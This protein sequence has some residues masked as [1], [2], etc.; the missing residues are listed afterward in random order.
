MKPSK[1]SLMLHRVANWVT[2]L[3]L[4]AA[5]LCAGPC[6]SLETREL[7]RKFFLKKNFPSVLKKYPTA[8]QLTA[9]ALC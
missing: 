2:N 1:A 4:S 6:S 9:R 3:S 7:E 5:F 8:K